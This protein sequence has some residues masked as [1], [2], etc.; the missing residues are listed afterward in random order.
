MSFGGGGFIGELTGRIVLDVSQ[1]VRGYGDIRREHR[2]LMED[3]RQLGISF[4]QAGAT[5]ASAGGAIIGGLVKA[6]LVAADFNKQMD[7]FGAVTNSNEQQM[8]ALRTAAIGWAQESIY[9]TNEVAQGIVELGK[10]GVDSQTLID[11]LGQAIINLGQAADI[12]MQEASQIMVSTMAQFSLEANEAVAVA[13][14]LSGTANASIIDMKDLGVTMKYAGGISHALGGNLKDLTTAIALLGQAGIK[15][16]T[17]GTSLR[18][19]MV[20]LN[21]STKPAKAAL[22]ELGII[23]ADGSNKFFD[24]QG[25][26]KPLPQV[27]E[28]LRTS[29]QGYS[30]QQQTAYLRTIFNNRALTAAA[31]L[32]KEGAAGFREMNAEIAKTT[33]ADVAAKRLDNLAGDIEILKG[34]V[35][36]FLLQAG[37]PFQDVL[38]GIT[39]G[40]TKLLVAFGNLPEG[41]Q[42]A[43]LWTVA[44]GGAILL[45]MGIFLMIT[46]TISLTIW[47]FYRLKDAWLVVKGAMAFTEGTKAAAI[48]TRLGNAAK[49]TAGLLPALA[50][51]LKAVAVATWA[52]NAALLA[53]PITWIVLLIVALIGAL[54]LCYIHFESFRNAVNAWWAEMVQEGQTFVDW[55]QSLPAKFSAAWAA[56]IATGQTIIDWFQALPGRIMAFIQSI[57]GRIM[58]GLAAIGQAFMS[59]GPLIMQGLAALPGILG[60]I[61]GT[62]IGWLI[63]LPAMALVGMLQFATMIMNGLAMLIPRLIGWVGF[64]L[65][66]MLGFFVR[67]VI[68]AVQGIIGLT[69]AFAT[70]LWNLLTF[71]ATWAVSATLAFISWLI[72]L[73]GQVIGFLVAVYNAFVS[74]IQTAIDWVRT[75][76][77]LIGQAIIDFLQALPGRVWSFIQQLPGMIRRGISAMV[78]AATE[79]G[80]NTVDA[81]IDVLTGLPDL[82]TGA[83]QDAIDALLDLGGAAWDAAQDFGNKMWEG[84]QAGLDMHSPSNIERALFQIV[85]TAKEESKNLASQVA[86]I[87]RTGRELATVSLSPGIDM[88]AYSELQKAVATTNQVQAAFMGTSTG[89]SAFGSWGTVPPWNDKTDEENQRPINV[90]L[91]SYNPVAEPTSETAI[92]EVTRLGTLG[93]FS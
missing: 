34:N 27:F 48:V 14:R 9:S 20:S 24:L 70:G 15:G 53:N 52:W 68:M 21:G 11:G 78:T 57:P 5:I 83:I 37:T 84:F 36:T 40:L 28:V 10:A 79:F 76:A 44:I 62:I 35:E 86:S 61:F 66:F 54:V 12:G 2:G 87:Q 69:I 23:T 42:A 6:S 91:N 72:A 39:Q 88:S 55:V 3:G 60:T 16:S 43:M 71:I 41:V 64:A 50:R 18:Q 75:N 51:S 8:K 17:A 56:V 93:V 74:G 25:N 49:W 46:G 4:T 29:L 89:P 73:P 7:Y 32:T 30:K 45:L 85:G 67:L 59:L 33:A 58:A 22:Q 82:V 13:D 81:I 26:I 31:I 92:K 77:P 19:M 90:E 63:R 38:R 80:Q 47:Q 65:G 1:A